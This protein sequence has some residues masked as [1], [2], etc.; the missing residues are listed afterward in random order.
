VGVTASET[1][2]EPIPTIYKAWVFGTKGAGV[3]MF[4]VGIE[5]LVRGAP[6]WAAVLLLAGAAVVVAPVR[7]PEEWPT[8]NRWRD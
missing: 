4:A 2:T 3:L 7:S 8:R 5:M 6:I 1:V